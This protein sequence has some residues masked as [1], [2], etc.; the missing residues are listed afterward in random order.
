MKK[1]VLLVLGALLV[2]VIAVVTAELLEPPR[3][4]PEPTEPLTDVAGA[5]P[6]VQVRPEEAPHLRQVQPPAP[7][8]QPSQPGQ[9][10][11]TAEP[12]PPVPEAP[13]AKV[14]PPSLMP[15]PANPPQWTKPL[16]VP[17]TPKPPNPFEPPPI[18]VDPERGRHPHAEQ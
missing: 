6:A 3:A 2:L 17:S 18:A 7:V 10:Q 11:G 1:R 9:A 8:P 14:V 5:A 13:P 4:T 12:P 16:A 15:D